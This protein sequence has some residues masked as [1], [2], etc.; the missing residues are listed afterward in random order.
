KVAVGG[1]MSIYSKSGRNGGANPYCKLWRL[2][3][4]TPG[5]IACGVTSIIF[6]LSPD[7]Q[8]PGSGVGTISSIS[9]SA[10]FRTV[11]R[12]FVAQWA[13]PRVQAIVKNINNYVFMGTDEAAHDL[14]TNT[15]DAAGKEDLT[16]S[17]NLVMASL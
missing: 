3:A 16:D 14:S 4:C 10:V 17:L 12:F 11:K 5:L 2:K 8:F 7:Q 15:D 13:H 1:K 6:L 9:Y